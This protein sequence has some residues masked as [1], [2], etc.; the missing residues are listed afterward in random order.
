MSAFIRITS[1]FAIIIVWLITRSRTGYDTVIV[2]IVC[3]PRDS[4]FIAFLFRF[5]RFIYVHGWLAFFKV[6]SDCKS[7]AMTY[8]TISIASVGRAQHPNTN[9]CTDQNAAQ[10][11]KINPF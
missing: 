4:I 6:H 9:H 1:L 3:E 5:C 10:E 7:N 11:K 8:N 2:V